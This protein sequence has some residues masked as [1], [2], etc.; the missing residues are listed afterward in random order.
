CIALCCH[1]TAHAQTSSVKGSISDTTEHVNLSNAAISVLR[2]TDS[3]LI[4]FT[5]SRQA[6][7]FALNKLP[8][9]KYILLITYPKY[10]DFIDE[11]TL[12]EGEELT[13]G[14]VNIIRKSQ[15]LQEVIVSRKIG[16]IRI[17]GDTLEFNADSFKVKEGATVEDLLKRLPG[18]QVNSK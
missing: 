4:G 15:L 1:F 2:K 17:K 10:A 13:L 12:K 18:M 5:R 6:G 9:G 8:A 16:A 3:V 14:K 11:I 7:D